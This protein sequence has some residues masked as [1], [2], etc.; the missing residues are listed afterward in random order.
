MLNDSFETQTLRKVN[1]KQTEKLLRDCEPFRCQAKSK[2]KCKKMH[3]ERL[4]FKN[5]KPNE[6]LPRCQPQNF[7]KTVTP[8]TT[9]MTFMNQKLNRGEGFQK[10]VSIETKAKPKQKRKG[11]NL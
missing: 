6:K 4:G 11:Q 5:T 10:N 8:Y 1:F 2:Q 7:R 3:E 9:G